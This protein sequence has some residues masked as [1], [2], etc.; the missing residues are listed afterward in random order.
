MNDIN[1]IDALYEALCL[2]GVQTVADLE[3]EYDRI[4]DALINN[5]GIQK[6]DK[7]Y[8]F[9]EIEFYHT[10]ADK[11]EGIECVTYFR[12]AD[13]LRYFFHKSG[14]DITFLSSEE[15]YGGIL[16]R[17][18]RCGEEFINGPHLVVDA[19]FDQFAAQHLPSDNYPLIVP[20]ET[21]A[22]VSPV[23]SW[24]YHITASE[25]QYRYTL[26]I[27]EWKEHKN[28]SAFPWDYKGNLRKR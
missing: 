27:G 17:A 20:V 1:T 28:Y 13:A 19:L 21:E 22:K 10:I 23:P 18:I 2:N 16:I 8:R 9:V 5:F 7:L 25:K 6:G 15:R 14:M 26:P 4:A 11:S 24:R 12:V 3:K